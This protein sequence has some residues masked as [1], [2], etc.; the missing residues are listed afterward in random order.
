MV[1]GALTPGFMGKLF[2]LDGKVALMTGGRGAL[3][4][5]MGAALADLGCDIAF[6]SRHETECAD[7]AKDIAARYGRRAIGLPIRQ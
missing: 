4:L 2:Q 7:I 6:A 3:A 5:A 1:D